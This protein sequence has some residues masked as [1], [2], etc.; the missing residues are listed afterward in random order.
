[1]VLYGED[2][3]K[4]FIESL[5]KQGVRAELTKPRSQLSIYK[6]EYSCSAKQLF[7]TDGEVKQHE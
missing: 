5:V 2:S 3:R 6:Q 1:M 4:R 7:K